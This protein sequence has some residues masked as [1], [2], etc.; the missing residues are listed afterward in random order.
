MNYYESVVI[1]YLRADRA[2]FVNTECCLQVNQADNPD[3]SGP[4]WYCD[5][6]AADFRSKTVFLCEI[7]YGSQLS[8][9][10]K[11]LKGW[12]ENWKG[13]CRA[14]VRDSFLPEP[15]PVRPWLFIPE[16][17]VPLLLKRLAQIQTGRLSTFDPRITP[18]EM[19]QPWLYR[20][21]NRID[22]ATK[23]PVIP[24]EMVK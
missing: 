21:F 3:K 11:R 23:P 2:L 8:D 17:L 12:H 4:H 22:E 1:D 20:S 5:A 6:V 18:L 15:W 24:Q 10:T 9:L 14:L 7:S 13:V 16:K 19:V